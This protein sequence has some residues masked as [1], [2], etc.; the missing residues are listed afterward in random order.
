MFEIA[1]N[2]AEVFGILLFLI[3]TISGYRVG[4]LVFRRTRG[5]MRR[6]ARWNLV[7][8]G[9]NFAVILL[10]LAMALMS[11]AVDWEFASNRIVVVLP[12]MVGPAIAVA[13]L[14]V[15]R[16]RALR[17]AKPD[18]PAAPVPVEDRARA[19]DPLLVVPVQAAAIG[20]VLDMW[21]VFISRPSP[22]YGPTLLID[23]PLLVVAAGLLYLRQRRRVRVLT[24]RETIGGG[25]W[26][27]RGL[28]TAGALAL[29]SAVAVTWAAIG[30]KQS[31]LPDHLNMSAMSTMDYGGGPSGVDHNHTNPGP[32]KGLGHDSGTARSVT[33]LTG[34][35]DGTPTV[36]YTLTAEQKQITLASGKKID[37]WVFNGQAPGPELTMHVDDLVEVTLVNKLPN[38][39]VTLHWHGLDVP[40]AEDGVAGITQDDV[41]PGQS[42]TYRFK[43]EQ[44]GTFWYHSHQASEQAVDRGLFGPMVVLPKGAPVGVEGLD[45]TIMAHSWKDVTTGGA[46]TQWGGGGD[47]VAMGTN[48]T[49][50]RRAIMPG[51][52]VKL[53]LINTSDDPKED[54]KPRTFTLSG[55]PF[56]VSAIDGTDLNQPG[57]LTNT[58]LEMAVGGRYDLTFT[59]PD[60]PVRLTDLTNP[61]GGLL[62]S[63]DGKGD[64]ANP[65]PADAPVFDPIGYGKPAATPFSPAGPFNRQFTYYIDDRLAFYDGHLFP[66]P[67]INGH[68]FPDIPQ[69]MVAEGDLVKM[70]FINRGHLDHP[71]HLHGHHAL[72]LTHDG[73]TATG[74]PWWTDT[75]NVKP[76]EILTMAFRADNPGLWMDHCHNQ[77]HAAQGMVMHLGYIGVTTPYEIGHGTTNNPE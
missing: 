49:L 55:T 29:I 47:L 20:A 71:M 69:A 18:D 44:V 23:W 65:V 57:D 14:S 40:N 25:R 15:P 19:A 63:P 66:R 7:Q 39:G 3:W 24:G 46:D 74:S 1:Q 61:S 21:N 26:Y 64:V 6:S 34:P 30:I 36:K 11:W 5:K 42:Y 17:R 60:H 13:V 53:R 50:D 37:G 2:F 75:L 62:L 59:M 77:R 33:D 76:G 31:R 45:T 12:L 68:T 41:L 35:R 22:P 4:R 72:V 70:T 73:R 38:E 48:D 54:A 52:P 9:F 16:L 28:R 51:V 67:V 8:L 43:P 56:K 10:Q 27:V 58:R 32:G